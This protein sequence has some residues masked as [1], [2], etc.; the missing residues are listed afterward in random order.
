MRP[1]LLSGD[2]LSECLTNYARSA[3]RAVSAF[4]MTGERLTAGEL[5]EAATGAAHGFLAAGVRPGE[6][7]GIVAPTSARFLTS[8]FGVV[9]AGAAASV[10]PL[11][12]GVGGKQA[13][14]KRI[15]SI[16]RA[17]GMRHLLV[18]SSF[19]ELGA[20]LRE[21]MP[22]VDLVDASDHAPGGL[23][24]LPSIAADD[25]AVVQFTSGSTNAPKGVLLPHRTVVAGLLACVLSGEF[26]PD[27]V[28]VQWVPI[29]H[30]MGLIG[31]FSHLLNGADVHVFPPS[32]FLRRPW[33][34]LDYFAEHRGTV[35]T[36]PNFSYDHLMD[37]VDGEHIA[38]LDLSSWRLAFN[39]AEPVSAATVRRFA[40]VF[41]SAG[42]RD[43]VMYPAYGMAE[44]TLSISYPE[45][46]SVARIVTVDRDALGTAARVVPADHPR[47]K[48]LV[49]VGKPVEGMRIRV[50]AEHGGECADGEL[51]EIQISGP[52]VTTGYYQAPQL[53]A[54]AFDGQWF[55]TGD[56]GFWMGSELFVGGRAR[57]MIIVRGQN[58][59]PEDVEAIAR[60]TSGVHRGRCLAF[61]DTAPDIGEHIVVVLEADA[62]RQDTEQLRSAVA[63]RVAADLGL[64]AIRVHVVKPSWLTR[65][66]SG[67]WQ[68]ALARKRLAELSRPADLTGPEL[69]SR[70]P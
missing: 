26:S 37:S 22:E 31:L 68:R 5:D 17:A 9:R 36:G 61:S 52:A 27:D 47:A 15:A 8:F 70:A 23:H 13:T 12:T 34:V 25:L 14:A 1:P 67:K 43:S 69:E 58:Y 55:R 16:A 39:G 65:T 20:A 28:F 59:F 33:H 51:G 54:A 57:E 46:G 53:T 30:D 63:R 49:S 62:R 41:A 11:S 6:L 10:L 44:A 42:V 60:Q 32:T 66:T 35:L 2:T 3:P 45:P 4:P 21:V 40:E 24:S 19:A 64:A 38:C 56:L 48:E 50:V 7:V 18:E 29:F